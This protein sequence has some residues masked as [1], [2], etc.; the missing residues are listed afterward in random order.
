MKKEL[1][2]FTASQRRELLK[3]W[4]QKSQKQTVD[5][6]LNDAE[7]R[8]ECWLR[9][10]AR[11][12]HTSAAK[13]IAT[14]NRLNAAAAEML[15]ALNDLPADVA[16][17]LNVGWIHE[18]YGNKHFQK[19]HNAYD[20]DRKANVSRMREQLAAAIVGNEPPPIAKEVDKLPPDFLKQLPGVKGWLEPLAHAAR[21]M[22]SMM[23]EA[24]Q[25]NR[26]ELEEN[27]I[28]SL[29]IGYRE[30]F[31]KPPSSANGSSFR[32]FAAGLSKIL[33]GYERF[34][35]NIVKKSCEAVA[36]MPPDCFNR[37]DL[38]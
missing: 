26:K 24:K 37:K 2:A 17:L 23:A 20:A 11:K 25:W 18:A 30:C 9:N 12:P 34:G 27:L 15:A 36:S 1:F 35:A 21:D 4:V 8:I 22:A 31:G 6:F 5:R 3:C 29:A 10:E 19:I 28:F 33:T 16:E 38:G 32:R 13:T 7:F 14:L